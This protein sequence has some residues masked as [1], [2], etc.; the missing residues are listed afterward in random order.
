MEYIKKYKS[1]IYVFLTILIIFYILCPIFIGHQGHPIIDNGREAYIPMEMLKGKILYKDIINLYGPLSYQINAILF[2]IFGQNLNT[3]YFAGI[4]NSII[5]LLSFYLIARTLTSKKL[6]WATTFFILISCVFNYYHTSYIFPYCYS[7]SYALSG[8]LLSVLFFIYYLKNSR[9]RYLLISGFFMGLSLASKTEFVPFVIISGIIILFSKSFQIKNLM[10]YILCLLAVPLISIFSLIFQGVG[11]S[12]Y[13]EYSRFMINIVSLPSFKFFYT[14]VVGFFFSKS[15]FFE[16][17]NL[18]LMFIIK[19]F[20]SIALIYIILLFLDNKIGHI[21]WYKVIK[22]IS[23]IILLIIIP[24]SGIKSISTDNSFSW[25]PIS[26]TLILFFLIIRQFINFMKYKKILE[27]ENT[28]KNMKLGLII[29]NIYT[30]IERIEIKDKI[31]ITIVL[32]GLVATFKSY[33]FIKLHVFGTFL[34]PLALLVN[35]VFV[36]DYLPKLFKIPNREAWALACVM[37]VTLIG[38]FIQSDY[39]YISSNIKTVPIKTER[40]VIYSDKY[41]G[42]PLNETLDYIKNNIPKDKTFLMI[43][44]GPM[45]NFLTDRASDN[46]YYNLI[47]T[48]V[49]AYGEDKIVND[50][51]KKSPDYI[52]INN[53][54]TLE[55]IYQFFGVD[56]GFK[57]QNFV[58]NNYNFVTEYGNNMFKIKIYK[59]KIL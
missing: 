58:D 9:L 13:L 26:T 27:P 18:F 10:L 34:I 50:L 4:A 54:D 49:L 51:S 8:F 44:E 33:F 24:K 37:V 45:L 56:Y 17:L 6:S 16:S 1:D 36:A 25:L 23:I 20:Q 19:Y 2:F 5:I 41:F 52:F 32:A 38:L 21:K 14:N 31:F 59:H 7:I 28:E 46:K 15:V 22:I 57:I 47:P 12:D 48:F 39:T 30:I 35:V 55:L 43:P 3:L 53:R 11:L 42:I 29:K 40:G